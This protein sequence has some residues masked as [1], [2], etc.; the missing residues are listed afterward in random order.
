MCPIHGLIMADDRALALV[1]TTVERACRQTLLPSRVTIE[2]CDLAIP[3]CRKRPSRKWYH[4]PMGSTWG[5]HLTQALQKNTE[6]FCCVCVYF[7]FF[8]IMDKWH[9]LDFGVM[10]KLYFMCCSRFWIKVDS[11]ELWVL[12]Y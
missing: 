10:D 3:R 8:L 6:W 7:L 5:T 11:L 12:D 9:I 1:C 4:H 2:S